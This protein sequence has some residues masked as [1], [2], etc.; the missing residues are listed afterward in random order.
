M[1]QLL[2]HAFQEAAKLPPEEQDVFANWLLTEL[3]DQHWDSLLAKS[4]DQLVQ[5]AAEAVAEHKAGLT[6][7]LDPD[8]L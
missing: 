5:L 8:H 4:H 1:T 2:Q 7:P 3:A 6:V